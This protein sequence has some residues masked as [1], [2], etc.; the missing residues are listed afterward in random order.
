MGP[1]VDLVQ[2]FTSL[3]LQYSIYSYQPV[4]GQFVQYLN[5]NSKKQKG[6]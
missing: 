1:F 4:F 2:G 6:Q 5:M 3:L